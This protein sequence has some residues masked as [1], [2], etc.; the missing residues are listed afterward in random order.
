[1]ITKVVF[2]PSVSK[3]LLKK[4]YKIIDIKP[5]HDNKDATVFVF[6]IENE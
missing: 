3:N 1:M 4:G 5:R 2:K 6:E